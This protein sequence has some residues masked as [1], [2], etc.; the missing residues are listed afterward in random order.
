MTDN[1]NAQAG[2]N[3]FIS[4]ADFINRKIEHKQIVTKFLSTK[5]T[6]VLEQVYDEIKQEYE[7]PET[8]SVQNYTPAGSSILHSSDNPEVYSFCKEV[9]EMLQQN[10]FKY[11]A[12]STQSK[13]Y[14]YLGFVCTFKKESSFWTFN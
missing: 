13:V 11:K 6:Q 12:D 9:A 1:T 14:N 8:I 4:Y 7:L 10:G 5:K 3:T 2:P